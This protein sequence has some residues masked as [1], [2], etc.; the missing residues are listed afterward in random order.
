MYTASEILEE[1]EIARSNG[2]LAHTAKVDGDFMARVGCTCYTCRDVFDPTGEEDAK[3]R[4]N[5]PPPPPQP[6]LTRQDAACLDCKEQHSCSDVCHPTERSQLSLP[7]PPPAIRQ[8][9]YCRLTSDGALSLSPRSTSSDSKSIEETYLEMEY[10]L[11]RQLTKLAS[12]YEKLQLHID[13]QYEIPGIKHDEMAAYDAWSN[14][15]EE[16]QIAV[17]ELLDL[18]KE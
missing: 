8:C 5:V 6:K 1:R 9:N 18:L 3:A 10:H 13:N 17:K 2:T 11:R 15:T 4:N 12:I 7:P 16:K 14:E